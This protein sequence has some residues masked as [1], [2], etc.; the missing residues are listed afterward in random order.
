MAASAER[1]HA[2]LGVALGVTGCIFLT[3]S[4]NNKA[5]KLKRVLL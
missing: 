5:T 2:I 4:A 1:E 3:K